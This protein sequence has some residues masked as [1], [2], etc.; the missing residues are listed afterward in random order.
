MRKIKR[1]VALLL[2]MALLA[3]CTGCGAGSLLVGT[4]TDADQTLT[5]TLNKDG[6][7]VV[8]ALQRTDFLYSGV[9]RNGRA[10]A[11]L[12][13]RN[14]RMTGCFPQRSP[15]RQRTMRR[16]REARRTV[17]RRRFALK[18]MILNRYPAACRQR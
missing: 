8:T 5:M 13:C 4:W 10:D 9:R 16:G 2:A 17:C 18:K 6:T 14:R 7:A 12:G 1:I 11:P 3:L 15:K